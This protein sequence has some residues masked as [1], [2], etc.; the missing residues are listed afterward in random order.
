MKCLEPGC[1]RRKH[2]RGL[3]DRHYQK[4][5]YNCL[6]LPPRTSLKDRLM[7]RI[8]VREDCGCWEWQG[9]RRIDGY[10][11]IRV[12]G[13]TLVTHRVAAHVFSA[14]DLSSPMKVCHY[15]D[16]PPCVNPKHLFI[17]THSDNMQDMVAK[18]RISLKNGVESANAKLN[19]W[20]VLRIRFMKSLGEKNARIA[21]IFGVHN[22]TIW[23]IVN[24][25]SW[26]H[27]LSESH[28]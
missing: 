23:G 12:D 3:C 28:S 18:G 25:R 8:V 21:D 10:G 17:R 24:S 9:R 16:N 20:K 1:D 11:Q 2:S 22:A 7:R 27:L 5:C 13:R 4:R 14:F 26:K 15:C 6:P 19:D